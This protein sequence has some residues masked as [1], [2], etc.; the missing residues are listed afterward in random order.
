MLFELSVE[1]GASHSSPTTKMA[2][3]A[4]KIEEKHQKILRQ[5]QSL[6]ENKVCAECPARVSF[7]SVFDGLIRRLTG[8][9]IC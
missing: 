6:P 4:K 9:R 8:T 1:K 7:I 5:L 3:T 2:Q